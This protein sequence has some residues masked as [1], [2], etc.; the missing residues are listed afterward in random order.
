MQKYAF[1]K[2]TF[3]ITSGLFYVHYSNSWRKCCIR[4]LSVLLS[5][6]QKVMFGYVISTEGTDQ[7]IWTLIPPPP[8]KEIVWPNDQVLCQA[9]RT[10]RNLDLYFLQQRQEFQLLCYTLFTQ[11]NKNGKSFYL[12]FIW[13]FLQKFHNYFFLTSVKVIAKYLLWLKQIKFLYKKK[14]TASK[15]VCKYIKIFKQC[16][17]ITAIFNTCTRKIHRQWMFVVC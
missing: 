16:K 2:F 3:I 1:L 4:L 11:P 14:I 12:F 10:G 15:F 6:D 8:P 9:F 17:S 5:H 13:L 7:P